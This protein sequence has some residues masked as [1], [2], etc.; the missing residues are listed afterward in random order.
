M[1][2]QKQKIYYGVNN[3]FQIIRIIRQ[4]RKIFIEAVRTVTKFNT[5]LGFEHVWNWEQEETP[6]AFR[7]NNP[8]G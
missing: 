1:I 3:K 2:F 5:R 8:T 4:H 7:H 6:K